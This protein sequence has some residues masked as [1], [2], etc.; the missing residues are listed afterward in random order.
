MREHLGSGHSD[1]GEIY[2]SASVGGG[3]KGNHY[4]ERT[5]EWFCPILGRGRIH[6]V[7]VDTGTEEAILLDSEAP[8]CVRIPPRMAHA[9]VGHSQNG[10]VV[11]AYADKQYDPRDTD[12]VPFRVLADRDSA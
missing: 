10:L 5:T 11:L 4:H 12:T 8:V 3:V 1:F 2:L 6:T 7:E 9:I